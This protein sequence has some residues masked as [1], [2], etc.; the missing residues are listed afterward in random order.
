MNKFDKL[1]SESQ[2]HSDFLN[3]YSNLIY[4]IIIEADQNDYLPFDEEII[5]EGFKNIFKE[6]N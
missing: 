3:R 5:L 2:K 4:K 6:I 1:L